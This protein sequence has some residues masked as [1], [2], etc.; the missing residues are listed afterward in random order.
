MSRLAPIF[1]VY[2]NHVYTSEVKCTAWVTLAV[3]GFS[4]EYP[5]SGI[6]VSE[7]PRTPV[8]HW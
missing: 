8:L 2:P 7:Y 6:P 4:R 1:C 5:I 3:L